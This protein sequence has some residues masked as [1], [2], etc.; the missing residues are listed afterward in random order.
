MA[1]VGSP[2]G[3]LAAITYTNVPS[4]GSPLGLLLAIT[5]HQGQD[6]NPPA[7]RIKTAARES[8]ACVVPVEGRTK[9][10]GE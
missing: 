4:Y 3:L 9:K 1:T 7:S 5:K 8:R 6:A 2:V 10:A